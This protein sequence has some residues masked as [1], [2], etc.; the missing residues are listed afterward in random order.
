MARFARRA[1][2][3]ASVVLVLAVLAGCTDPGTQAPGGDAP[4]ALTPEPAK[5]V[6]AGDL[7]AG[8]AIDAWA[9]VVLPENKPGGSNAIAR[10]SGTVA[11]GVEAMI[12]LTQPDGQWELTIV[13]Q[14]ADGSA[15]T[16]TP[17]PVETNELQ[18]LGCSSPD[19]SVHGDVGTIAFAGG[20]SGTLT[21]KTTVPAIYVYEIA[22]QS[23]A[24]D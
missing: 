10:V 16:M 6:D 18:P 1:G 9:A 13:C 4:L 11:P 17:A 14:S 8:S 3:A 5:S 2:V 15:L 19:G 21:L 20:S 24:Q 7:P 22:P 23:A 12:D